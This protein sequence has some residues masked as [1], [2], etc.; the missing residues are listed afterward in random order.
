MMR[1]Y[2]ISN[3]EVPCYQPRVHDALHTALTANS[4]GIL[5]TVFQTPV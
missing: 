3:Y 5:N 4:I 1:I 2:Q